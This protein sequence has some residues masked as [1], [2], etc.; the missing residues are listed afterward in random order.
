[1]QVVGEKERKERLVVAAAASSRANRRTFVTTSIVDDYSFAILF[2]DCGCNFICKPMPLKRGISFDQPATPVESD[3]LSLEN[4]D[5][6]P[7]ELYQHRSRRRSSAQIFDRKF[8]PSL[9]D[10][11]DNE[12]PV[13]EHVCECCLLFLS[14]SW[15]E[16][17]SFH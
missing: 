3:P 4:S 15:F 14:L 7:P 9:S 2:S 8:L 10:Q 1:M 6:D 11:I 17:F 12:F 16:L 13:P 5:D